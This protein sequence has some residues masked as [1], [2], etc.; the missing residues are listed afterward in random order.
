M[1][2]CGSPGCDRAGDIQRVSACRR[3]RIARWRSSVAPS[4]A[5]GYGKRAQHQDKE[6]GSRKIR[7]RRHCVP[8]L[9]YFCSVRP[10]N[11]APKYF[12]DLSKSNAIFA[13][14]ATS[15]PWQPLSTG[16]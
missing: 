4:T 11:L 10:N 6:N 13:V 2:Q 14:P 9:T 12:P 16:N 7:V 8:A 1:G 3:A 5:G 15:H